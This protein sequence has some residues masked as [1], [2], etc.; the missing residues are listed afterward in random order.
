MNLDEQIFKKRK[1]QKDRLTAYGFTKKNH[2]YF[3]RKNL[4]DLNFRVEISVCD[5]Q[6]E[7][8]VIDNET[9]EE[10]LPLYTA[11]LRGSF[12]SRVREQ[13]VAILEDIAEK[14]FTKHTFLFAQTDRLSQYLTEQIKD[15]P[16]NPFKKYPAITSF[17][18]R[19]M[20]R[21]YALIMNIKAIKL[22]KEDNENADR[23]IEIVNLK[24]TDEL[25]PQLIKRKGIF[26]AYHM[27][28]NKWISVILDDSLSD[29]EL[30]SLV[31][32]SRN[33]VVDS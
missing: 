8:S 15:K 16:D 27:N 24:S 5:S 26:R 18:P 6:V 23:E 3:F 21:W 19:G 7:T 13:T 1:P 14:C 31:M 11:V 4:P 20:K 10:Y 25:V 33:L 2:G 12:V 29:N 32:Q 17:R 22:L 9:D 28:H 30:F